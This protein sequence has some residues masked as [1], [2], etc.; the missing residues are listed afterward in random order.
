MILIIQPFEQ[1]VALPALLLDSLARLEPTPKD[2]TAPLI[3]VNILTAG[4]AGL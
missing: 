4:T 2:A 1:S 3:A